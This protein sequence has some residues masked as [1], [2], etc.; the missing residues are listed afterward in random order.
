VTL[1][2]AASATITADSSG[3]YSFS[4]LANGTYAVTPG[5]AGY[6]FNPVVQSVT[7]SGANVTAVNFTATA[8]AQT[9]N[10]SGTI[11]PTTGGSGA[12]VTLSGAAS[13]TTTA[14]SS[15]SYTFAGLA[16][17]VYTVTPSNTGYTF[18]PGSQNVTIS[19]ANVSAVNFTSTAQTFNISGTISPTTGGSGAAVA[20]SGAASATT[21]TSSSG[22]YA[23]TGL[24]NGTY[25]V[26]PSN[27]GYTFSPG[28]QNVT[29]SGNN[30]TGLNFTAAAQVAH[31]AIL[32]WI[33]STSTVGGYNIYRSSVSGGPYAKTNS[34]LITLLAYT[35]TTVL[36]GQTYYYVATS[37][38][39]SNVE[40]SYSNEISAAIPIP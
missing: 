35:D 8:T 18:S 37:V 36:A 10:I 27:T 4:G 34:S 24:A 6:T 14:S 13:G 33:A 19:G 3:N 1:S 15:G 28:S 9:F 25:T 5:K 7:V 20:L 2:G 23:F 26:T 21:T 31:S 16:N 32:S 22:S 30:V 29:I 39:A 38:N 40:S 12:T 11:S 17:G